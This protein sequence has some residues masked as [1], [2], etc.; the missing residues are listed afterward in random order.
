MKVEVSLQ[1]KSDSRSVANEPSYDF[2]SPSRAESPSLRL[3]VNEPSRAYIPQLGHKP[4]RAEPMSRLGL[5]LG[6]LSSV[7]S[8]KCKGISAR[9]CYNLN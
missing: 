8:V 7:G 2:G 4:S 6:E 3:R 9:R 5:G 1:W